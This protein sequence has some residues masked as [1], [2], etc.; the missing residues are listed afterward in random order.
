MKRIHFHDLNFTKSEGSKGFSFFNFLF[1]SNSDLLGRID[2]WLVSKMLGGLNNPPISIVLWN[3][4]EISNLSPTEKPVTRIFIK[5]RISVIKLIVNPELN[6]GDLYSAGKIDIEGDMGAFIGLIYLHIHNKGKKSFISKF[7]IKRPRINSLSDSRKNVHHHY[8]I[9]NEFYKIWLDRKAMQYT[10]AYFPDSKY[11]S[12]NR[13]NCKDA[14]HM[15]Q[16]S[17]ATGTVSCRSWLWLGWFCPVY[18]ER[19]WRE[20]ESL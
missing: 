5:D 9:G 3:N 20:R 13:T 14:P 2:V 15:P 8:D 18:G 17:S 1:S 4:E 10:C 11:D 12:G 19:I 6:F 7:L 16:T